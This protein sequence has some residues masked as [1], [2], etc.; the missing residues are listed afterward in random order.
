[1]GTEGACMEELKKE[2]T[3]LIQT[4]NDHEKLQLIYRFIKRLID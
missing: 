2:I 1:M 3:K 4:V